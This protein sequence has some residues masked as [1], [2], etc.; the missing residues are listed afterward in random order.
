MNRASGLPSIFFSDLLD[1]RKMY[2][3]G[4]WPSQ[5]AH[6]HKFSGSDEQKELIGGIDGVMDVAW[7]EYFGMHMS[8][9]GQGGRLHADCLVSVVIAA[10]K[11]DNRHVIEREVRERNIGDA[12]VGWNLKKKEKEDEVDYLV[13]F[14]GCE[15]LIEGRGYGEKLERELKTVK[16]ME[17]VKVSYMKRTDVEGNGDTKGLFSP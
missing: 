11:G 12:V 17:S 10:E 8:H 5:E 1:E 15:G 4:G 7:M 14:K 16:G 2:V 13:L 9:V 3:I 6:Q